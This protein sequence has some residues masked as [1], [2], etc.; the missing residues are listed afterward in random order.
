MRFVHSLTLISSV[1]IAFGAQSCGKGPEAK[2]KTPPD[3]LFAADF[4]A[5]DAL[6]EADL[7]KADRES[8]GNF[9]R[10]FGGTTKANIKNYLHARLKYFIVPGDPEASFEPSG[11]YSLDARAEGDQGRVAA[12]NVGLGAWLNGAI[13]G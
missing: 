9:A 4:A 11:I 8:G 10:V 2:K 6:K 5:L 7:E 1:V 13:Y 12:T 3:V